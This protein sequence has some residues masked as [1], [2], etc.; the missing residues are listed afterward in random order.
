MPNDLEPLRALARAH[1]LAG[2]TVINDTGLA[3][4]LVKDVPFVVLRMVQSDHDNPVQGYQRYD[5]DP[6]VIIQCGNEANVQHDTDHWLK[7]MH[8]AEADGR[9]VVI[10]NDSVGA[11]T[12]AMWLER[13]PALEYA[14]AHHHFC[15]LHC[16]G[17]V[18]FGGDYYKPMIDPDDPGSFPW[19]TGRVFH[20]YGLMPPQAQP[21]FIATEAGAGGSQLNGTAEQWLADVR[22]MDAYCQAY[23]WFKAFNLWTLTRLG[24]G[25][26]RDMID[27]YVH[28]L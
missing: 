12:D 1:K 25:F 26:D 19:F 28:L 23:P 24:L 14:K 8:D 2:V 4:E 21:D 6:R 20:L 11:T 15:G 10:F 13:R 5:A 18:T 22:R 9:R 16:Y 27:G 3:N 17:N 7:Q